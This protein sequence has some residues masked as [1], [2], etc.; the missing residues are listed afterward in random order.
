MS[1][2]ELSGQL[3]FIDPSWDYCQLIAFNIVGIPLSHHL[4]VSRLV[5]D[6]WN[7][8]LFLCTL[9]EILRSRTRK[10]RNRE[11]S[12]QA[13]TLWLTLL[14]SKVHLGRLSGCLAALFCSLLAP[15]LSTSS[16]FVPTAFHCYRTINLQNVSSFGLCHCVTLSNV[17]VSICTYA[18]SINTALLIFIEIYRSR[19][20]LHYVCGA[21]CSSCAVCGRP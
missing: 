18:D 15:V 14:L 10:S 2:I 16:F 11:I 8:I 21:I 3:K 5:G 9:Y 7:K 6:L 12:N 13:V 19:F 1:R 4:S 20:R 17:L